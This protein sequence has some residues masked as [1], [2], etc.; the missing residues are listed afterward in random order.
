M[1]RKIIDEDIENI[2]SNDLAWDKFANKTILITGANGFLPAYMVETLCHLNDVK[3]YNIKIF[4]LARNKEKTFARFCTYL[5]RNYL[6]FFFQDVCLP[7]NISDKIDYIIHAASQASPKYYAIDPVGTLSANVLG[8]HHLLELAKLHKVERF[9]Y[10]SSGEVYGEVDVTQVPIKEN[11]FGYLDP[12]HIRS[13]YAES[14]RM[15]ENM[16]ISY[17]HQYQLHVNIARPFHIYGPGLSLDDGRVYADFSADIFYDRDITIHGKGTA[18]R[19]FCYLAD[20]TLG[21]FT[22]LL[23][24]ENAEAY[25][26][27]NLDC[28]LSIMELAV[29]LKNLFND[30][31]LKVVKKS[32]SFQSEYLESKISVNIPDIKKIQTLGWSPKITIEE[33]FLRTIKSCYELVYVQG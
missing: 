1:N 2:I 26:V 13:C 4:A 9:L 19:S 28:S 33:G 12:T 3:K 10:F 6:K 22:I 24:G 17:A 15:G 25:N 14:K 5:N 11:T 30:R 7:I 29:K 32:R 16:C 21:F 31:Q 27:G 20:A 18:I 8:T 23:K